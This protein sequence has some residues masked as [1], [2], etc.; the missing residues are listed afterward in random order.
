ML[1]HLADEVAPVAPLLIPLG[2]AVGAL[3]IIALCAIVTALVAALV[4][5]LNKTVGRL[6]LVG[7]IIS[8]AAHNVEDGVTSTLAGWSDSA[9]RHLGS[10]L[11]SMARMIDWIGH[12]L[13]Q[14][15]RLLNMLA[16]IALGPAFAA[17][18][19]QLIDRLLHAQ[20]AQ[21]AVNQAQLRDNH[22]TRVQVKSAAR[23][24][25][26][27]HSTAVAIPGRLSR[28]WDIPRLRDQVKGLE[29]GAVD[30]WK[31]IR[32]HPRSLAS[33]AFAGAVAWA[34]G[35]VG[36]SWIRCN[37][38]NQN[39]KALCRSNPGWWEDLLA[40][41][42]ALVGTLS[43]VEFVKDLQAVESEAVDSFAAVIREFPGV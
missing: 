12:E 37:P 25:H 19:G 28:E 11:H 20:H 18:I 41:S 27:A 16:G 42:I 24:A 43:I 35:R 2:E 13:E 10:A 26:V 34:L 21:Q 17:T 31:W 7:G 4:Y 23:E 39:A 8:V 30:T 15:A 29:D 40:G 9:F 3:T 1:H 32:S 22:T 38:F 6:P 36:A 5:V 33:G 14:H